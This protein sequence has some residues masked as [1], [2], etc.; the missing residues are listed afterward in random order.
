MKAREEDVGF[1]F[2]QLFFVIDWRTLQRR[3]GLREVLG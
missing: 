1:S 3:Q 2:F